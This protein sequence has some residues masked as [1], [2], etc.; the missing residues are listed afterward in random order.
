MSHRGR[1][2]VLANTV[3]KPLSQI[4][5]EF[6]GNDPGSYQ[7]SGDVKYHLGA[8][9][10]H[11]ADTGETIAVS[12]APNPSHLEF[13]NPV[14][15]G[16]VRAKQD[17]LG[18]RDHERVLPLLLHGDAAFA[19]QGVVAET[20][21]LSALHGYRTGGTIHVVVNN[22][23]G[24][25]TPPRG[26]P[27]L[28]LRLRRGQDGPRPRLPRERRRPRGGGL[29]RGAG[30]RVPAEVPQG[31]GGRPRLLPALGT[32]RD[33]RAQLHPAAHVL[34]D[35]EPSLGGDP[36][37][38]RARARRGGDRRGAGAGVGRGEGGHAV[39]GRAAHRA[40]RRHRPPRRRS[41]PPPVDESAMLGRLRT[42]SRPSGRFPTASRSIPSSCPSSAA[43]RSCSRGGERWTGPRRSRWPGGRSSSR[44]SRCGCPGRTRAAARS[45]SVTRCSPT[46]GPARSTSRST[47]PPPGGPASRSTTRSSPRPR[48]WASSSATRWP[49]TAALVMWEAQFG[50]FMNGAQ[51]IIDQF[52]SCSEQKWGQ[53][54]GLVLLLPHGHEG[55][56]PEHSS[57]RIER[58]LILCAE[59]NM[60]LAY[61]STPASY[62]HL[63]R[64][65]GRDSVEKPLV[66]F[67][68]KSLLRHPALRL[69][70]AGAGGR[71]LRARARR[72]RPRTPRGPAGWSCAP[73]RSTTTCSR[74]GRTAGTADVALVRLEQLYP[75]P[76]GE[77]Q[78]GPRAVRPVGR[79]GLG[80]GGAPQH[81]GLALRER[82]RSRRARR[83][84]GPHPAT[85][86]AGTPPPPPPPARSG[87]TSPS[88]RPSCARPCSR[89]SGSLAAG[90]RVRG[91]LVR[92]AQLSWSRAR[93]GPRRRQ[94]RTMST[95]AEAPSRQREVLEAAVI[96]FAGDSGDGMQITGNQFTNTAALFGN[97]LAT[98]PDYPAEIR[99]PAGT[100]PGVSGFQVHFGA[101]DIN[102][103][104]D[105]ARRARGDEPGGAEGQPVRPQAERDPR[106][107]RRQLQGHRPPQGAADVEP[108]RGPLA[109]TGTGVFP[110]ELTKLT[111]AAL[112]RRR[113][114]HQ[115]H[116]PVQELLRPR[117]VL[118]ALQPAARR[119]RALA[120][121]EVR[122]K[123]VLAEA[124][125][126]ALKAGFAYCD[127]TQAFQVRY[128]VPPAKLAPGTYRNLSGNTALALGFVA[129]AQQA[130]LTLF[131]GCYPITPASDILHELAALQG[132][133]GR[134]LPGRG[135]DRRG[136][137]RHRG[138][139]RRVA[140][141]H[142]HLG[143]GHGP[144]GR[145]HRSGDD[146]R[147]APGRRQRPAG[148]SLDRA[149]RPRPSRP[150]CSRPSTAATPRRRSRCS[151]PTRRATASGWPSRP[152]A[153]PSS[154]CSR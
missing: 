145:G 109:S 153:S 140:G 96:R 16:M 120:R 44:A 22:Q 116:G 101:R 47:P 6:E 110:V 80:P 76:S 36:V 71:P 97:D 135:R 53:P 64:W 33:R 117:H 106:R 1:L 14:V 35:Q 130:G 142:H 65:Q 123:P 129:A 79:A 9:G 13:V 148:R 78:D 154:T 74:P 86:W 41:E 69:H 60:R 143:P 10:T 88:R 57:A 2:N 107:Q 56:G 94:E 51:V 21:H 127:A 62:F 105:A 75:L 77:L 134:D 141:H 20:M 32:Q 5:A 119:H 131:Q 150:T 12:L 58:F 30:P 121:R 15:E 55:Q 139:L 82:G 39:G 87:P 28:H 144:Q 128:E 24:F 11:E 104:G 68:P 114:R 147:A 48:S 146:D 38:R 133:R 124:N 118:L 152:A 7:G 70:P 83:R 67:T 37:R 125:K 115:E 61:P 66:V 99:A 98:F 85:T 45:R 34:P 3:G 100:L 23:I 52:L 95:T 126:L 103:P 43:G 122:A 59:D 25:T 149:A 72:S 90:G 63:L 113:P 46:F 42:V 112:A 81:G 111:R 151:R 89:S 132:V 54:T 27:E 40:V 18:D 102:T 29:R 4:F 49:S 84:R 108:P 17:A 8:T 93:T 73:A 137:R 26:R 19:G 138:R 50:D 91:I 92:R 31:R 136:H